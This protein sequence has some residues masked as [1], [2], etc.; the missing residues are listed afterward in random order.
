MPQ[1][2]TFARP[3][4]VQLDKLQKNIS[5]L[6]Q[7]TGKFQNYNSDVLEGVLSRIFD[8]ESVIKRN[9]DLMK[10]NSEL[11]KLIVEKNYQIQFYIE[12]IKI[13][14]TKAN[15]LSDIVKEDTNVQE[16]LAVVNKKRYQ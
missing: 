15:A 12:D 16:I 11:E 10:R 1:D 14:S 4:P 7:V 6:E 3:N 5:D 8:N 2:C 13:V 9:D